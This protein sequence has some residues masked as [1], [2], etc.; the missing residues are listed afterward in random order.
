MAVNSKTLKSYF[1]RILIFSLFIPLIISVTLLW[2]FVSNTNEKI[3]IA[4][5]QLKRTYD[6]EITDSLHKFQSILNIFAQSEELKFYFNSTIDSEIRNK[7]NL[8]KVIQLV[9]KDFKFQE[10]KWFVINSRGIVIINY[11]QDAIKTK[12]SKEFDKNIGVTLDNIN[13][14]I[15]FI[16]PISYKL[17]NDSNIVKKNLGYICVLIHLDEIKKVFPDLVSVDKIAKDLDIK[18]LQTKVKIEYQSANN[19]LIFYLYIFISFLFVLFGTIWGFKIFQQNIVD[20][21]LFLRARVRNE[22]EY[23]EKK[24]LKNEL[25]SLSQTFDLYLRY[26]LFLQKEILKSSQLA[27]AGNVAHYMAHDIRKPFSKLRF[28]IQELKNLKDISEIKLA[29]QDFEPTFIISMEYIEHILNEVMDAAVTKL[30]ITKGVPIESVLIMAFNNLGTLPENTK[31]NIDY[32][33]SNYLLLS[34]DLQRVVRIIVNIISNAL[35]AMSYVGNLWI[36]SKEITFDD[37]V[38]M[39]ICIGNNNSFISEENIENIFEP[40]YTYKK[41]KGTGL[42]LSI[43]QK[44]VKLHGGKIYCKSHLNKGVE[45][46]F[47]LPALIGTYEKSNFQLIKN[48]NGKKLELLK[49]K[50]DNKINLLKEN[51]IIVLD[52][53]PLVCRSWERAFKSRNTVTFL[54]PEDCIYFMNENKNDLDKIEMIIS[55]YFF[56]KNS[57]INFD[58]FVEKVRKNYSG[59]IFLSSDITLEEKKLFNQLNIIIIEKRVYSYE[60]LLNLLKLNS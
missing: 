46:I 1:V 36:F 34:I 30:N 32:N 14:S 47:H 15:Q 11:P 16:V 17:S 37:K 5:N 18:K 38:F 12:L 57:K 6:L 53:D 26:T 33:L 3:K 10:T 35:E 55:D 19:I 54:N 50:I 28:F 22:M 40:F 25:S 24:E 58:N 60:E 51:T 52:D 59:K 9:L 56:G 7:D 41:E 2:T 21:I 29:I 48:L 13:N 43:A 23:I 27:A 39:E 45:F 42:G 20:K 31:I 49:L 4:N 8:I 44:I